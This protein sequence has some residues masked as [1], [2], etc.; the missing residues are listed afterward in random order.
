MVSGLGEKVEGKKLGGK[1]EV[2]EVKKE[3]YVKIDGKNEL[4]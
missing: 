2:E 1:K 3:K 4:P